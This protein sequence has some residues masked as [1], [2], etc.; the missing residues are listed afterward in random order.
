M[1]VF[2]PSKVACY[3]S[4]P[5]LLNIYVI[6]TTY[7]NCPSNHAMALGSTQPLVK[8]STRNISWG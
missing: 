8:I 5:S 2:I 4:D 3:S 7:T 1:I 6:R